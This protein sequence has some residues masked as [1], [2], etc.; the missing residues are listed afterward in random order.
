MRTA[1]PKAYLGKTNAE[2]ARIGLAP[3]LSDGY[4]AKLHH[5]GQNSQGPLVEIHGLLHDPAN[6]EAFRALHG[7]FAGK[8]HPHFPVD[9]NSGKWSTDRNAYWKWRAA[10]ANQ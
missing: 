2:A 8:G 6:Q 1:G 7:Q 3:Q 9:H 4:F 10:N 5:I